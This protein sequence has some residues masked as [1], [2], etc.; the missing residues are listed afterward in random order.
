LYPFIEHEKYNR[1]FA[2]TETHE[3][4]I[5]DESFYVSL[6]SI[7]VN[8]PL[9]FDIAINYFAS[10]H[11]SSFES[12]RNIV[13]VFN[14]LPHIVHLCLRR[15]SVDD[16]VLL[17][18]YKYQNYVWVSITLYHVNSVTPRW[19]N[20]HVLPIS[21]LYV[22]TIFLEAHAALTQNPTLAVASR[23]I[24]Y[25]CVV[26]MSYFVIAF[27]YPLYKQ[28]VIYGESLSNWLNSIDHEM[29][30]AIVLFTALLFCCGLFVIPIQGFTY[31]RN[32]S[33][34]Y[35]KEYFFLHFG[36][37]SLLNLLTTILPGRSGLMAATKLQNQL[38][39]KA[40]FVR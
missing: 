5:S 22:S 8:I 29:Y 26:F 24:F 32:G 7:A 15:Y 30:A 38:D 2:G 28:Y 34:V 18:L 19:H 6:I 13:F 3:Y 20:S 35:S 12:R 9:A 16:T 39:M 10:S 23:G 11:R 31:L 21:A 14:I 37:V 1:F 4:L 17:F 36:I 33:Y 40:N 27:Y 25:S